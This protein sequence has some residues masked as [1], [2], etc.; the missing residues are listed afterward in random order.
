MTGETFEELHKRLLKNQRKYDQ[1]PQSTR[2]R[3]SFV[4]WFRRALGFG[5]VTKSRSS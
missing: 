2:S 4:D 3:R 1:P 5:N